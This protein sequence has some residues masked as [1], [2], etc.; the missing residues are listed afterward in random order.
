MDR[1]VGRLMDRLNEFGI[2]ENTIVFFTSDN[3][4]HK[5]G[6][7][8][9]EIFNSSGPLR[10][11]KRDLYDGGIRVPMIARWPGT[12]NA[13]QTSDQVW[14]FWDFLPTAVELA[15][16]QPPDDIDGISMVQT[17]RLLGMGGIKRMQGQHEY[18]YWEYHEREFSQA[19]R[20]GDWKAV[21]KGIDLPV[22][23]YDVSTDIGETKNIANEHP[24]VVKRMEDYL[25]TARTENE[26]WPVK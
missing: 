8:D 17:L 22:E 24:D 12:L 1:D 25:K 3:G 10:G 7:A 13:G 18:L 2:E 23:L 19:V 4:T 9:P 5:E 11:Y 26:H 20:S 14:A 6:G 21:R 15:G 16:G